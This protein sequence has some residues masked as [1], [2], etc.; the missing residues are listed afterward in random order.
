MNNPVSV[1]DF[2]YKSISNNPVSV[3]DF[4]YNLG[5][6]FYTAF[7][8]S[9][10]LKKSHLVQAVDVEMEVKTDIDSV[11]DN[12]SIVFTRVLNVLNKC[13]CR[14]DAITGLVTPSSR[15]SIECVIAVSFPANTHKR[16]VDTFNLNVWCR[17]E[18]R[19][20]GNYIV[21]TF[22]ADD[23]STTIN[24]DEFSDCYEEAACSITNQIM[25]KL[26]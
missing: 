24:Q 13:V 17:F 23:T 22:H 2:R 21:C 4:P 10:N 20:S 8:S 19:P 7:E 5:G 25:Q 18:G 14:V 12:T 26:A 16:K 11:E 1:G 6:V 3:R 15:E 9:D